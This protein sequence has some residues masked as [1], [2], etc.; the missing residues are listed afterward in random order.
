MLKAELI[1]ECLTYEISLAYTPSAI[2][3]TKLRFLFFKKAQQFALFFFTSY[4]HNLFKIRCK[5]SKNI[6]IT[7]GKYVFSFSFR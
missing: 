5:Y 6:I 1:V 4:Y 2:D 7:S 3:G